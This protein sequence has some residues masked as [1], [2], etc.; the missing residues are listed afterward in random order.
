MDA[1]GIRTMAFQIASQ[2]PA[3]T[4]DAAA[5]L[6]LAAELIRYAEARQAGSDQERVLAFRVVP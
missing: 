6:A 1:D 5:I 3:D 2:L 4:K